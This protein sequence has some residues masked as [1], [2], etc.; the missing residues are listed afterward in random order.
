MEVKE[1]E[2]LICPLSQDETAVHCVAKK[3][4]WWCPVASEHGECL[5]H[6]ITGYLGEIVRAS[7]YHM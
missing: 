2:R 6:T 1:A 4:M 7:R 5:I 3:C